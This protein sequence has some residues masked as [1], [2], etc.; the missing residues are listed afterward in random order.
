MWARVCDSS[1]RLSSIHIEVSWRLI[2]APILFKITFASVFKAT[3]WIILL[4]DGL[5]FHG[6]QKRR[7]IVPAGQLNN[8]IFSPFS[9]YHPHTDCF[10]HRYDFQCEFPSIL[11]HRPK[12]QQ[13]KFASNIFKPIASSLLTFSHLFETVFLSLSCHFSWGTW[14]DDVD[15]IF[16]CIHPDKW[17][18]FLFDGKRTDE[19]IEIDKITKIASL[20][21]DGNENVLV[22]CCKCSCIFMQLTSFQSTCKI[23]R[24]LHVKSTMCITQIAALILSLQWLTISL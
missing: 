3:Q 7:P 5:H 24:K 21:C 6:R 19:T 1:D 14:D 23:A 18:K 12:Q 9:C 2:R 16:F 4:I 15:Q 8:D 17:V 20:K 13:L 22:A 10:C 11:W